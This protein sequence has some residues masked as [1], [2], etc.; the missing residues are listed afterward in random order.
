VEAYLA[1][2]TEADVVQLVADVATGNYVDA[3]I[4]AVG[5]AVLGVNGAMLTPLKTIAGK[6]GGRIFYVGEGAESL[7]R[8]IAAQTGYKTIYHTWYGALGQRVT[9]FLSQSTSRRMWA[10][11]SAKFANGAKHGDD[12]ITV[13][14]RHRSTGLHTLPIN[15]QAAWKTVEFPILQSKG[16]PYRPILTN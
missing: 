2:E 13:F 1:L 16:I 14:G 9:P 4:S 6:R 7:A 8:N 12:I 10:A 15:S 5:M 3:T 11:L